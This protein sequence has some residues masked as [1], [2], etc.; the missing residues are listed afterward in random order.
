MTDH[1]PLIERTIIGRPVVVRRE[2]TRTGASAGWW[3]AVL[4][5]VVAI[6]S[7][8]FLFDRPPSDAQLQAAQDQGRAQAAVDAA[9]VQAQTAAQSA[10]ISASTASA[11]AADSQSQASRAAAENA[12]ARA[13]RAAQDAATNA[14]DTASDE[15][16]R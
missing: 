5:A 12:G 6:A 16:P 4:V 9:A 10:Q 14:S 2:V 11:N 1:D 13:S 3:V 8:V 7:L 15:N